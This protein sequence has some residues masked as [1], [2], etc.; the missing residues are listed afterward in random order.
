MRRMSTVLITVI[1]ISVA[2]WAV[3]QAPAS[4]PVDVRK[5][6]QQIKQF[7]AP[8]IQQQIEQSMKMANQEFQEQ[9]QKVREKLQAVHRSIGDVRGKGLMLGV[10]LV[11]D[12]GTK[13][14]ATKETLD[15]LDAAREAG[16]LIGKGGID[17]NVLRIKP[18]LCITA[19][20][21]DFAVEVLD[22][23]LR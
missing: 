5:L 4:G 2:S 6:Q 16:L 1:L 12:R 23:A 14:P 18:P 19:A 3:A 9:M 17:G 13:E 11:R 8:V 20:D 15:V 21:V 7:E 22:Q 10:E